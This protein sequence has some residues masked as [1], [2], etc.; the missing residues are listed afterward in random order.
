MQQCPFCSLIH[1]GCMIV[2]QL[3]QDITKLVQATYIKDRDPGMIF[4]SHPKSQ[5]YEADDR[6]GVPCRWS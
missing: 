6:A 4:V 1:P 5:P 3:R 2:S